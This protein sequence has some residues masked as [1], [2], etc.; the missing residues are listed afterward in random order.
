MIKRNKSFYERKKEV[1]IKTWTFQERIANIKKKRKVHVMNFWIGLLNRVHIKKE[2]FINTGSL[3]KNEIS[4]VFTK[5][6]WYFKNREIWCLSSQKKI[7]NK[8]IFFL[9]WNNMFTEYGKFLVFNFAETG[10][11]ISFYSKSWCR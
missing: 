3:Q 10:N 7:K 2:I 8:M 6:T 1:I 9:A 4:F 5:L 11:T